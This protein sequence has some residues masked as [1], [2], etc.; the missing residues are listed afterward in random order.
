MLQIKYGKI[1]F[2]VKGKVHPVTCHE[3]T[4]DE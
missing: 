2:S 3:G 4:K 1:Y